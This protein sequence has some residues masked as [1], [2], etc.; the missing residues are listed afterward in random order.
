MQLGPL[1]KKELLCRA[2]RPWSSFYNK[3][4]GRLT[5]LAFIDSNGLSVDRQGGRST[6]DCVYSFKQRNMEG[7]VYAVAYHECQLVG[8]AV[9]EM[10]SK[11]N[12]YHCEIHGGINDVVLSKEQAFKLAFNARCLCRDIKTFEK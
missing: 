9:L 8:A 11:D 2:V 1:D 10:P 3:K 5:D 7:A 6:D 4:N 12:I